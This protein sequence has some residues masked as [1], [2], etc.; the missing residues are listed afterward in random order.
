MCGEVWPG[1]SSPDTDVHGA[2][3]DTGEATV[4][5]PASVQSRLQLAVDA[6]GNMSHGVRL[7]ES[8]E[9][10]GPA[11]KALR[12]ASNLLDAR[13]EARSDTLHGHPRTGG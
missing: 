4:M 9:R 3:T 1:H 7:A 13:L 11:G 2:L 12:S 10:R 6:S 8:N 5:W